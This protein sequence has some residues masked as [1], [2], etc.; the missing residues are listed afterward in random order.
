MRAARQSAEASDRPSAAG[1]RERRTADETT[2][3]LRIRFRVLKAEQHQK[4]TDALN[5]MPSMLG[6]KIFQ[7]GIS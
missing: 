6:S 5:E 3:S 2:P 1:G 7:Q 4:Q